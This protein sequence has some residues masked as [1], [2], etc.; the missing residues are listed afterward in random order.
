MAS[1]QKTMTNRQGAGHVGVSAQLAHVLV[2]DENRQHR[3][4]LAD[5]HRRSEVGERG[6][7]D[8]HRAGRDG[9]MTTAA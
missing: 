7:K 4:A 8:H 3:V 5:E 2:V 1:E 9:G 6:H